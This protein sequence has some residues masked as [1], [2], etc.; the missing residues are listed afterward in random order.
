MQLITTEKWMRIELTDLEAVSEP[1]ILMSRQRPAM[2][3]QVH[4]RH[5]GRPR[6]RDAEGLPAMP[7]RPRWQA[8]TA[9]VR[10]TKLGVD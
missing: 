2:R 4:L 8:S 7:H 9:L 5:R 3:V 6:S 10:A 1:E